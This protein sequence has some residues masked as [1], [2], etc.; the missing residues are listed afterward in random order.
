MKEHDLSHLAMS[1]LDAICYISDIETDELLYL[2]EIGRKH[3]G[4]EKRDL[5]GRKCY[6][7]L[8]GRTE[9]CSFCTND[10]LTAEAFYK[11][12]FYN[13]VMDLYFELLDTQVEIDGKTC[14]LEFA[15]DIT[16]TKKKLTTLKTKLTFE[17]TLLKCAQSLSEHKNMKDA[18]NNLLAIICQFFEGDR[19]YIFELSEDGQ[20]IDNTYEWNADGIEPQ[21][22]NLQNVPKEYVGSW[23]DRFERQGE[24]FITSL[25]T[26][27]EVNSDIYDILEPQGIDSLM[28]APLI[29][30]NQTIGFLGVD[31]PRTNTLDTALI[32]SVTLFVTSEL[33]KK[34]MND[35]LES[36]I[37]IDSF[38][39]IYNRN[40]YIQ[41]IDD[42]I[43][44]KPT[45]V[46]IIYLDINELKQANDDYGH[47]YGDNMILKLVELAKRV[48]PYDLFRI[49]GD[50]FIGL[51]FE[52]NRTEFE[53][54]SSELQ[55][56][57]DKN[58]DISVSMGIIWC[59]DTPDIINQIV[60]ADECMYENK[61]KYYDSKGISGKAARNR[62]SL[63]AQIGYDNNVC[64]S[65]T[66]TEC[67]DEESSE[68]LLN[69]ILNES[70]EQDK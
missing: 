1:K 28:A 2:N 45:T 9:K 3:L 20:A 35:E 30:D 64:Q 14:R 40:K 41:V 8:Q 59:V 6:E 55:R 32:R 21:I 69:T 66:I 51:Y 26:D 65:D 5:T 68:K 54:L 4:V 22:Q 34:K 62:H 36:S 7:V 25:N 24:F 43:A 18:I 15:F 57:I 46:G 13:P 37:Y 67:L 50:E 48:F 52:E 38:T 10:Q 29:I 27:V 23:F 53:K 61:Q 17:E 60:K 33:E 63:T 31:N 42:I 11:W 49:G 70:H 39:K 16:D 19:S 12:E 56:E 47:E 58:T 44:N